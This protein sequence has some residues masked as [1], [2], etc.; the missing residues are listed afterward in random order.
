MSGDRST[1][2]SSVDESLERHL[3]KLTS[4]YYK[5]D[6]AECEK[7]IH[8]DVKLIDDDSLWKL[9]DTDKQGN[10]SYKHSVK[11]DKIWYLKCEAWISEGTFEGV[12]LLMDDKFNEL[13]YTWQPVYVKGMRVDTVADNVEIIYGA[14]R[15]GSEPV[16]AGRDCLYARAKH[17]LDDGRYVMS[18]RTI[19]T[20]KNVKLD[21]NFIP[22]QFSGCTI[23]SP[24]TSSDG[25]KGF[26]YTFF[27]HCEAGG[28]LNV[29]QGFANRQ[30]SKMQ[31]SEIKGIRNAV[32]NPILYQ[33]Q[34]QQQ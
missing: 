26:K 27:Q 24:S 33:Q 25:K 4:E 7:W 10:K 28:M 13:Q 21:S 34:Q 1:I 11:G 18:A 17:T 6:A 15:S 31:L 8:N 12:K 2:P 20:P 9:V 14:H 16:I 23:L 30:M 5:Y 32:A 22:V 29:F 3:Q 19:K